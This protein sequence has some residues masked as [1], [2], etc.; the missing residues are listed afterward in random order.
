MFFRERFNARARMITSQELLFAEK[1]ITW[2]N[3][4]SNDMGGRDIGEWLVRE[5][6]K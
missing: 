4:G 5:P 2:H 3:M 1:G 6:Y